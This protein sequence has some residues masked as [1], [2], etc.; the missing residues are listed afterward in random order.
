MKCPDCDG[1]AFLIDIGRHVSSRG[2][3]GIVSFGKTY[4][5]PKCGWDSSR[6]PLSS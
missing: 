4:G 2:I 5:C 6:T 3:A 1:Q